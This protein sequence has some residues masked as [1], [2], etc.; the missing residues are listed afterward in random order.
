MDYALIGQTYSAPFDWKTGKNNWPI[1]MEWYAQAI[2]SKNCK[3]MM[4]DVSKR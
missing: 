3:L 4:I 2:P 1:K